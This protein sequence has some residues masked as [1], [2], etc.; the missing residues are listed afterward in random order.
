M[1]ENF[2]AELEKNMYDSRVLDTSGVDRL[3]SSAK[4]VIN[5]DHNR[6]LEYATPRYNWT[7]DNWPSINL[8]WLRS[9]AASNA[10]ALRPSRDR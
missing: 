7:D 6:W 3:L 10:A 8:A 1:P 5:T 9:F 4:P 2:L